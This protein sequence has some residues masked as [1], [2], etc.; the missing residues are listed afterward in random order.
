MHVVC[1]CARAKEQLT[2][3]LFYCVRPWVRL[4][5]YITTDLYP[6]PCLFCLGLFCLFS[7]SKTGFLREVCEPDWPPTPRNLPV[8]SSCMASLYKPRTASNSSSFYPC[9]LG[10][11]ITG[12]H[13]LPCF[14]REKK[15]TSYSII[16]KEN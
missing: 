11:R 16:P 3:F 9:L 5:K 2:C 10:A 15:F 7:F 4:G 6:Q 14:K 8:S 12:T 13:H 1:V